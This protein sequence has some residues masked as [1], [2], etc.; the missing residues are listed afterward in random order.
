MDL[1]TP[2]PEQEKPAPQKLQD[3]IVSF[4]DRLVEERRQRARER[5]LQRTEQLSELNS[6][7]VRIRAWEKL[8]GL[9]LPGDPDHPIL[10]LIA[11]NTRLTI[12]Q[13]RDAQARRNQ[14]AAKAPP[15]SS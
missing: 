5:H 14:H 15:R 10:E 12:A 7:D 1:P 6:P 3:R 4:G 11:I 13:V 8:H 9:N 2:P